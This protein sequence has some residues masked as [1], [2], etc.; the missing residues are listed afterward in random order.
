MII[1]CESFSWKALQIE[2]FQAILVSP[3]F[4]C[5]SWYQFTLW[6]LTYQWLEWFKTC[7]HTSLSLLLQEAVVWVEVFV[8]WHC[9]EWGCNPSHSRWSWWS[10]NWVF[11]CR[12]YFGMGIQWDTVSANLNT[13]V[14]HVSLSDSCRLWW[15][16]TENV[17]RNVNL[18]STVTPHSLKMAWL[19]RNAHKRKFLSSRFCIKTSAK[20]LW[21]RVDSRLIPLAL[22]PCYHITMVGAQW[23]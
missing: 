13:G 9:S 19:L 3:S 16:T 4:P 12:K 23:M 2:V 6:F 15:Q 11:D 7:M 5:L 8:P 20:I 17:D 14:L 1:E 10:A 22:I 18:W 21:K